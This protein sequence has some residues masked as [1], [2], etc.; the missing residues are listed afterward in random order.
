MIPPPIPVDVYEHLIHVG[1]SIPRGEIL[2]KTGKRKKN[3]I[4]L[5]WLRTNACLKCD[6]H[7]SI[8]G[9]HVDEKGMSMK[10]PDEH[11]IPLCNLRCHINGIHQGEKTFLA[12]IEPLKIYGDY[13]FQFVTLSYMAFFILLDLGELERPGSP[14]RLVAYAFHEMA[15]DRRIID[16]IQP[17]IYGQG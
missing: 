7:F 5:K 14:A 17:H 3:P 16:L 11:T 1:A 10:C 4:Y 2:D 6:G 15:T 12:S 13:A 8:A 9:H